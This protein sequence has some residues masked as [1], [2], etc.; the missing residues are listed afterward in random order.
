VG[1]GLHSYLTYMRD[2]LLLARD[3]LTPSGS[4]FVQI[5]DE[6]LH[7]IRELMDEVFGVE[8]A[9]STI[10]VSKDGGPWRCRTS[11]R[12]RLCALVRA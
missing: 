3:S 11:D 10:T 5:S 1:T 2:R 6:N 4:V 12:V 8:N 9:C 7:H